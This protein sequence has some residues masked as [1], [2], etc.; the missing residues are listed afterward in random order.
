MGMS[1]FVRPVQPL[2]AELPMLVT[3][4]PMVTLVRP[5]Q[6]LNAELP[7]LVTELGIVTFV[8]PV[9]PLNA[10]LPMLVT[11]SPMIYVVTCSPK[12]FLRLPFF[13]TSLLLMVTLV[14]LVQPSNA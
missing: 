7:M 3:E 13:N 9:Q 11:L 1:M 8:R 5:V 10:E 6:P 2:N 12:S 4:L 14:R